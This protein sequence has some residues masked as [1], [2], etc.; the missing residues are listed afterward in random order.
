LSALTVDLFSN[1]PPPAIA[2]G[3]ENAIVHVVFLNLGLFGRNRDKPF[4]KGE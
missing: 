2:A 1:G 3:H 4:H